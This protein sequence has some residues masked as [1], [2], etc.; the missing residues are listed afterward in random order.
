MTLTV[1]NGYGQ[2]ADAYLN[3]AD[4]A[5]YWAAVNRPIPLDACKEFRVVDEP[6]Y[7][8]AKQARAVYWHNEQAMAEYR[9]SRKGRARSSEEIS[10]MRSAF[11]AGATV[12]DVITRERITL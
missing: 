12:I 7:D 4:G 11:G 3:N 6:R 5:F 8:E 2:K 10:E 9:R 1:T